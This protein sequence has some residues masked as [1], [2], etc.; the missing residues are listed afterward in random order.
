[1]PYLVEVS[2]HIYHRVLAALHALSHVLFYA[3]WVCIGKSK[4]NTIRHREYIYVQLHN[5]QEWRAV[6][7]GVILGSKSASTILRRIENA[8]AHNE[9]RVIDPHN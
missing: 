1:M 8:S 3:F 2:L 7:K 5:Q 9:R 6:E 4:T